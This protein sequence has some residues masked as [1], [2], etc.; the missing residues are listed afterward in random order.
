MTPRAVEIRPAA[1]G[2]AVLAGPG[3][4]GPVA[5]CWAGV[6]AGPVAWACG[7]GGPAL[8]AAARRQPLRLPAVGRRPAAGCLA[9]RAWRAVGG[10][11]D[12]AGRAGRRPQSG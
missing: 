6:L 10:W 11:P 12:S 7:A 3:R 1:V 4:V 9:W 8:S 5:A 2:R